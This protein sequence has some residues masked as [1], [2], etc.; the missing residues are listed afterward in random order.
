MINSLEDNKIRWMENAKEFSNRKKKLVG[1]VAKACAFVSYCGPFNAE[2]RR[3]LTIDYFQADLESRGIPAA[4]DLKL[5]EF[6]V[7]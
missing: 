7:D 3:K 2:Y 1:N 6:L 4:E 5:T